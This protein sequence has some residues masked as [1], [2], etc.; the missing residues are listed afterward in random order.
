MSILFT[1]NIKINFKHIHFDTRLK[2]FNNKT[3]LQRIKN[4]IC[5]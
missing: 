1:F 4:L 3:I 2:Y 5:A